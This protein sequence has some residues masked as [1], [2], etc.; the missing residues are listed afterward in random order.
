MVAAAVVLVEKVVVVEEVVIV[1]V[2]LE[3][4]VIEID[5]VVKVWDEEMLVEE[6]AAE[7]LDIVELLE[8]TDE[9]DEVVTDWVAEPVSKTSVEP[10]SLHNVS[11][12]P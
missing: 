7:E 12:E 4:P 10:P 8:D 5:D 1:A 2:L 3:G 6:I 9:E 11:I